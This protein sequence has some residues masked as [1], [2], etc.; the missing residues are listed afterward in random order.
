MSSDKENIPL[1]E[2]VTPP[3]L[4][5]L[6]LEEEANDNKNGA[7]SW[8]ASVARNVMM[9]PRASSPFPKQT[10][11]LEDLEPNTDDDSIDVTNYSERPANGQRSPQSKQAVM[12]HTMTQGHCPTPQNSP[13]YLPMNTVAAAPAKLHRT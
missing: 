1:T 13:T 8:E 11:T 6:S 2:S 7:T 9:T 12:T 3:S 5:I 10:S 4:K